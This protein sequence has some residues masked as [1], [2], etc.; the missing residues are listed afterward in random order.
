MNQSSLV[1]VQRAE[2][3]EIVT[4]AIAVTPLHYR[5]ELVQAFTYLAECYTLS[6][7]QSHLAD[8]QRLIDTAKADNTAALAKMTASLQGEI[9]QLRS[10]TQKGLIVIGNAITGLSDR[11]ERLEN[12]PIANSRVTTVNV[13]LNDVGQAIALLIIGVLSVAAV[14]TLLTPTIDTYHQQTQEVK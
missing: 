13:N 8:I 3:T 5:E 10:E 12:Q 14:G 1:P 6:R 2:I 4:E 11:V 7:Q 9:D